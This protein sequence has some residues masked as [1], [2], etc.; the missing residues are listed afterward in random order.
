MTQTLRCSIVFLISLGVLCGDLPQAWAQTRAQNEAQN[1]A[2]KEAGGQIHGAGAQLAISQQAISQEAVSQQAVSQQTPAKVVVKKDGVLPR[3]QDRPDL[4]A[5]PNPALGR[6]AKELARAAREYGPVPPQP[7]PHRTGVVK[8]SPGVV[9]NIELADPRAM[10][11]NRPKLRQFDPELKALSRPFHGT[12]IPVPD[13][14]GRYCSIVYPSGGWAL[15]AIPGVSDPCGQLRKDA[16]GGTTMRAGLWSESGENNVMARCDNLFIL[17]RAVGAAPIDAAYADLEGQSNCVV[18]I[19]PT[20]LPIFGLPYGKTNNAQSDPSADVSIARG[21]DYNVYNVPMT[22]TLFG[23]TPAAYDPSAIWIDR[24]GRQRDYLYVDP[25]DGLTKRAD[26]EA[27]HDFPMPFG[28]PILAVADGEVVDARWRDVSQFGCGSD[29]QGEIYI[30][31]QVGTGVYAERFVTYYAHETSLNV[32]PGDKVTRGQVIG[33]A[34]DTG[35]SSGNHVHFGVFRT[36]NLSG[37]RSYVFE[38]TDDGYG[39]NGVQGTIDPFGWG[40]PQHIDPW[41]WMQLGEVDSRNAVQEPGAFSIKLW[42]NEEPPR[43]W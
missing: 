21:F 30:Y 10:K 17:Y 41:A 20:A 3:P 29:L 34:G 1:E 2:Q 31:H 36:T 8:L 4:M 7:A 15:G 9:K 16:P 38:L 42:R 13:G 24:Q 40:A 26:G 23:Q 18:T 11:A 37:A 5:M 35:C 25:A 14:Y 19:A 33:F 12:P 22:A 43:D 32:L 39:I 28:K 27:A 6:A